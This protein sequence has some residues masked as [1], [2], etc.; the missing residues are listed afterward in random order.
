MK[1]QISSCIIVAL[2]SERVNLSKC[3][4]YHYFKQQCDGE[5]K[6]L[7]LIPCTISSYVKIMHLFFAFSASH[8]SAPWTNRTKHALF[9]VH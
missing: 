2:S 9:P 7:L 4:Y 8:P 3:I 1:T 6:V 5:I